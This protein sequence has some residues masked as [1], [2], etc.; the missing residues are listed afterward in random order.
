MCGIAGFWTPG[1]MDA[2][3]PA[4]LTRMTGAIQHRGP[5]D[6]G[7]WTDSEVGLALGHRRLSVIDLSPEG[8]QPMRSRNSRYVMAFNGEIYNFRELRAGLEAHGT[9]FR[10]QSDT[11]I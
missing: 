8:H 9:T 5:D 11:E 2:S 7:C 3:G 4:V 6:E 10:G 1:G